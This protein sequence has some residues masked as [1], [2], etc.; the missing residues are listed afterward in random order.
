MLV[1]SP[2]FALL[3][4][5]LLVIFPHSFNAALSASALMRSVFVKVSA[6][7]A[8]SF[9]FVNHKGMGLYP[10]YKCFGGTGYPNSSNTGKGLYRTFLRTDI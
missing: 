1:L 6:V 8:I 2:G 5:H 7:R 4:V 9:W 3:S 10:I